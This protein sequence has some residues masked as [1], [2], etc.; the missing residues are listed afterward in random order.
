[1]ADDVPPA[2]SDTR[3][4]RVNLTVR[5]DLLIQA[6]KQKMNLSRFL[7]EILTEALRAER[8]RRWQEENR[9]ALE[10]FNRRIERDGPLNADLLAF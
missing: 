3:R 9:Q 7:E 1:M 8:A 2:R 10:H 6:R 5:A 4:S